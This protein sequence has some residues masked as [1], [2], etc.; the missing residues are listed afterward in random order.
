MWKQKMSDAEEI[1][2][3]VTFAR[4][5]LADYISLI[6]PWW[7]AAA[8]HLRVCD[9]LER[10]ERGECKR[11]IIQ[12]APRSGKSEMFSVHF[13]SWYLGRNPDK[14][15]IHASY[16]DELSNLFS[17]RVRNIIRDDERYR[18]IFPGVGVSADAQAVDHWE[19]DG[20]LGGFRSVGVG[21]G[22]TGWGFDLGI[23]DDPI[24]SWEAAE[25][26]KQRESLLAWFGS[27]FMSRQAPGAAVVLGGTTWHE[28]DL[29]HS[30]LD[31]DDWEIIKIAARDESGAP[32]WP[33]RFDHEAL[34]RIEKN[35]GP[36]AWNALYMSSP[37]GSSGL[38]FKQEWFNDTWT[39]LPPL[40]EVWSRWDTS[41]KER[42][43][44][45]R[46]ARITVA[47]GKDG[48]LY[49]ISGIAGHFTGDQISDALEQSFM[50]NTRRF[51][52]IYKGEHVEDVAAG[53]LMIQR[54]R[55]SR[56]NVVPVKV[57]RVGKLIRARGVA[58][59]V[60]SRRFR[61]PSIENWWS[62]IFLP[63]ITAFPLGAHDDCLDVFVGALERYGS[64]TD[65]V[66][67]RN[68]YGGES[69]RWRR[70]G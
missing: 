12:M 32:Y 37:T 25:S 65:A 20:K 53:A 55:G 40:E 6:S 70:P 67:E 18:V 68:V 16:G 29:F 2:A 66:T 60:E 24:K 41:L 51:G 59:L 27:E 64:F 8:H 33:D 11:L 52:S 49:G 10:V 1:G 57:P 46:T 43:Q 48:L 69:V 4:T 42:E 5:N 62:D 15:V 31:M 50:D 23:I 22:I 14:R 13:P 34:L 19:I 7:K 3:A 30:V 21:G 9:A 28:G 26:A 39:T 56:V 17:R 58:S 35:V 38:E 54:F 63:E 45:D 44:N 47:R 36:R 61:P